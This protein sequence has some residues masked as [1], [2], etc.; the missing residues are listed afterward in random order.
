M[1]IIVNSNSTTPAY[2][3]IYNQIRDMILNGSLQNGGKLPSERLFAQK[4]GVHRNTVVRAYSELKADGY[5][6]SRQG[7]GHVVTFTFRAEQSGAGTGGQPSPG[8]G[9]YWPAIMRDINRNGEPQFDYFLN[10]AYNYANRGDIISFA[11]G[12]ASPEVYST[13]IT[14]QVLRETISRDDSYTYV[15]VQGRRDLHHALSG[16]L[17]GKGI[18]VKG[19]EILVLSDTHQALDYTI[20]LLMSPGD[21]VIMEEPC[22][23]VINRQFAFKGINVVTTPVD[24]NGMMIECIEPLI[25]KHRPRLI[26][27]NSSYNDPTAAIMGTQRRKMLLDLSYKYGIPI[28]EDDWA[29]ELCYTDG[30][31]PSVK[32]LDAGDNVIYTYS[33]HLTFAP[34]ISVTL[35][36]GAREFIMNMTAL[37]SIKFVNVD[38]MSQSMLCSFIQKGLYQK[39][40][41]ESRQLYREKRD[42]ICDLLDEA[43]PLGLSFTRPAGGIYLWCRLPDEI[44]MQELIRTAGRNG[45]IFTPGNIFFAE[46]SRGRQYIRLNYTYPRKD[47]LV[48]GIRILIDAI[49]EC[50]K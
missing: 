30:G 49:R 18:D 22:Y 25:L 32:A 35:I 1:N 44:D 8:R 2:R 6:D 48:K 3:Q 46:G 39:S 50:L 21:T 23:P 12:V 33:F 14:E 43:R 24:E 37:M 45:V 17:K 47:Q 4:L 5:I 15:P 20:E 34:G 41:K 28:Y 29:S 27:I 9:I 42:L 40:L 7:I 16:F 13:H 38:N 10:Q 19:S 26:H 11:G 31:V 36:A